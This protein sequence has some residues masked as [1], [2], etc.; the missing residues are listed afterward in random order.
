M[1]IYVDFSIGWKATLCHEIRC[2]EMKVNQTAGH[3]SLY[4][5]PCCNQ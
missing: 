4:R 5:M 3:V 1:Y 2:Q